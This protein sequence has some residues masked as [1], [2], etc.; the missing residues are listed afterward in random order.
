MARKK[1]FFDGQPKLFTPS[2][3]R[4]L[5]EGTSPILNFTMGVSTG[6]VQSVTS[7]FRYDPP[8]SPIKSTQQIP[9]DWSKFENHTFFNS[10]E[11]KVNTAFDVI[12]NGYPFDGSRKENH[13]FH[14]E[15]T[16]YEN[17]IF[18]RFP[19]HRGYLNF[20]GS[21]ATTGGSFIEV[22]DRAGHYSPEL[23][24]DSSGEAILDNQTKPLT[25]DFHLHVPQGMAQQNQVL[26]QR[27]SGSLH[28][29]TV[30]IQAT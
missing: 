6:S 25:F 29:F 20:S 23:S 2:K 9:I 27:L 11:A 5:S 8:G 15:L 26:F 10:A 22:V 21:A 28:G 13:D 1:T 4:G 14:D 16:G 19:K 7:S 3:I 24:R 18:D 30:A 12:I 17:Y